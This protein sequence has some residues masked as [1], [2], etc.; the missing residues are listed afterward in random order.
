[1][2]DRRF[3]DV[4]IVVQGIAN[5]PAANPTAGTQYIVGQNPTGAFAG[6]TADTLARYDG[7]AWTFLPPQEGSL[8]VINIETGEILGYDG[9]D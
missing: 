6:V 5:E 2:L 9:S 3:F 4:N 1:M 8:E 7:S